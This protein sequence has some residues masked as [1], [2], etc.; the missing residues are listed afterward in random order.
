MLEDH[1]KDIFNAENKE[2]QKEANHCALID[3]HI[4]RLERKVL[5]LSVID[6]ESQSEEIIPVF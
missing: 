5:T 6:E 2:E 3:K 4:K 1:I